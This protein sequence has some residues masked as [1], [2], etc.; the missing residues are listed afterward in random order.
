[1]A[2][3]RIGDGSPGVINRVTIA[4]AVSLWLA[5]PASSP[6][7][8]FRIPNQ[9]A[10]AIGRGNAFVATADNPSA[11]YYNPAGISHLEGQTVQFGS[12]N[13]AVNS[14][15][16]SGTREFDTEW[17]VQPVPQ[18][19]YT[20]AFKDKPYAF[21]LG[22]FAPFGLGLEWP[23]NTTFNTLAQEG[24]LAYITLNPVAAW[25]ITEQLSVAAG[26]TF[27]YS[28]VELRQRIGLTP[29]D[30]FK[31]KGDDADFG[32]SAGILWQPHEQWS[33]GASY[34]SA[35][36][37]NYRGK[38][39]F[40]PYSAPNGTSAEL[41]FPQFV[42]A[43][44]SY[45]PTAKWNLEVGVDWTDWDTLDTVVFRDTANGDIPFPLN[46]KSSF[47]YHLGATY[48][49]NNPYYVS[50]GYF[51]SENSTSEE[52]FNP[53]V[54]D[55]DLHVASLGVGY[56]GKR[57]SWAVAGQLITGPKREVRG[58]SSIPSL[59]GQSADGDYQ[60]FNQALNFSLALHF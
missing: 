27:N 15:Y 9:D 4:L 32:F 24:R 7:L 48:Q 22:V 39:T 10:R 19:Y 31:Y 14:E 6:G 50:A 20:V 58:S 51:F 52:N 41:D 34:R 37:I 55:T 13:I 59:V 29:G 11:I 5:L 8:G 2:D 49:F 44:I 28:R 18:L 3:P 43:G 36:T 21:G 60:F 46:W 30:E 25:K 16:T 57:W 23:E 17:E 26:P 40:R 12:H 47:L 38:S 53:I 35:T 33:F 54:P 45:R 42:I 1:M 56:R